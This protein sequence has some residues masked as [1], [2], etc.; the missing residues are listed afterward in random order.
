MLAG[1]KGG[2]VREDREVEIGETTVTIGARYCLTQ[3]SFKDLRLVHGPEAM[4]TAF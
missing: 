3:R 4:K 1:E 2:K